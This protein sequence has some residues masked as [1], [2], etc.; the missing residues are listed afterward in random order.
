MTTTQENKIH[1]AIDGS[2]GVYCPSRFCTEYPKPDHL[3]QDDW[4]FVADS[5]NMEQDGYWD[6]WQDILDNATFEQDGHTWTVYQ[7][8]DVWLVRSDVE[9]D[10]DTDWFKVD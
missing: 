2:S 6:A 9:W 4:D 8:G 3:T 7:D 5:D 1:L 10:E